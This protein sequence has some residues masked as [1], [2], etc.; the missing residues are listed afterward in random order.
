MKKQTLINIFL[1]SMFFITCKNNKKD[2]VADEHI[3]LKNKNEGLFIGKLSSISQGLWNGLFFQDNSG[4]SICIHECEDVIN[5]L[6]EYEKQLIDSIFATPQNFIGKIFKIK[7]KIIAPKQYQEGDAMEASCTEDPFLTSIFYPAMG[8]ER[9]K[10]SILASKNENR[11]AE[12]DFQNDPFIGDWTTLESDI[13]GI[14]ISR[15]NNKY[16]VTELNSD[17]EPLSLDLKNNKLIRNNYFIELAISADKNSIIEHGYYGNRVL[18]KKTL[19]LKKENVSEKIMTFKECLCGAHSCMLQFID[20][21]RELHEF[22]MEDI[23]NYNFD[24]PDGK[25][26]INRKFKITYKTRIDSYDNKC[27]DSLISIS[28]V[29]S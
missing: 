22:D 11:K 21:D 6:S 25:K 26:Y 23:K 24:C 14:K 15:E 10:D 8:S 16:L 27:Y 1:V 17:A 18:Y 19:N 12:V 13:V 7:W 5:Y 3:D 9:Q 29:E 20:D 2:I 4:D 28:L